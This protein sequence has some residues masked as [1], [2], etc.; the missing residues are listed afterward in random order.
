MISCAGNLVRSSHVASKSKT[1]KY[2]TSPNGGGAAGTRVEGMQQGAD[3]RPCGEPCGMHLKTHYQRKGGRISPLA[4]GAHRPLSPRLPLVP[5]KKLPDL[6]TWTS[7][8]RRLVNTCRRLSSPANR[9]HATQHLG[10]SLVEKYLILKTGPCPPPSS[11][12]RRDAILV[13]GRA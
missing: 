3:R 12:S 1:A 6:Y 4:G 11:S 10:L 7:T 2:C 13:L 9:N 5:R 8:M